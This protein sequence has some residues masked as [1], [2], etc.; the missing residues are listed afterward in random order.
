MQLSGNVTINAPRQR[1]WDFLT[2]PQKAGQCAPG[3]ERVEIVEPG[4]KFRATVAVGFG[5]MKAR[6]T[7]EA[8]W[9][10]LEPPHRAKMKAHGSAPGSAADVAAEMILA[11]GPEGATEMRWTAEPAVMGQLASLASRMM[12]SVSQKLAQ[13]FYENVKKMIEQENG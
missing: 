6:F 10:E 5:A 1:V 11:D 3:V 12:A 9:L 13:Q 4:R 7:G 8:E 2:D